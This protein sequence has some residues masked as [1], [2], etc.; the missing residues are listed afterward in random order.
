MIFHSKRIFRNA[1]EEEFYKDKLAYLIADDRLDDVE[2][3]RC[4][5]DAVQRRREEDE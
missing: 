2:T 1:N 3:E 5:W 4:A